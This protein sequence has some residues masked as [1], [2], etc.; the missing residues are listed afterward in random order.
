MNSRHS[1]VNS[2]LPVIDSRSSD[3][4]PRPRFLK[5]V[6]LKGRVEASSRQSPVAGR[7]F[8]TEFRRL[9]TPVRQSGEANLKIRGFKSAGLGFRSFAQIVQST[10]CLDH[11]GRCCRCI[12]REGRL[13][14]GPHREHE[15]LSVLRG[16]VHTGSGFKLTIP[17]R[18]SSF[19]LSVFT[20]KTATTGR[21]ERPL[22]IR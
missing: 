3:V 2:T 11:S 19:C 16:A 15:G 5:F 18:R 10:T 1:V 4:D 22:D 7:R 13:N 8:E 17:R 12:C 21:F 6:A 9:E 14:A 20:A